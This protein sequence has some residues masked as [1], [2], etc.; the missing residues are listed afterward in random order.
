MEKSG[1]YIARTKKGAVIEYGPLWDV[2]NSKTMKRTAIVLNGYFNTIKEEVQELWEKGSGEGSGL[3]MNDGVT[4]C[5]NVL[6]SIFQHVQGSEKIDLT[7]LDNHEIVEIIQPYAKIVG[8]HFA[9]LTPEQMIQFRSLRG[10][11]GQTTGTRRV[12]ECIKKVIPSFDPPGL[13][14]FLER[15][16]AQTTMRAFEEYNKIELIIQ[17]TVLSELKNEFGHNEKD[18]WFGGVPQK[19]S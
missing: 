19:C 16:K 7:K 11:Q 2:D 8:Q 14:E 13:H 12:E 17:Q 18:W 10:S 3:S 9:S 4:V 5:I 1:F 6:R 15:E